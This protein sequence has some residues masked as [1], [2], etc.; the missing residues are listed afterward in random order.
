MRRADGC[1][2]SPLE[3]G[4]LRSPRATGKGRGRAADIR[5]VVRYHAGGTTNNM[6]LLQIKGGSGGEFANGSHA[7][8]APLPKL[9]GPQQDG[10][11]V[12]GS[13]WRCSCRS[14]GQAYPR[15][16]VGTRIRHL[17][18]ESGSLRQQR[19]RARLLSQY[20]KRRPNISLLPGGPP[21]S[22]SAT[23]RRKQ[24]R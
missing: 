8:S 23:R 6:V 20:K 16:R 21:G 22:A 24:E 11:A 15:F 3:R 14:S 13:G 7:V 19:Q 12:F 4:C 5:S 10:G 17:L 18:M 2:Q 1:R 9:G